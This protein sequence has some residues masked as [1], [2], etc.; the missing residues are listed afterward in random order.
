MDQ[1][2]RNGSLYQKKS[3]QMTE[4][5]P[6]RTARRAEI[7]GQESEHTGKRSYDDTTGRARVEGGPPLRVPRE[8]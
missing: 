3:A 5:H 8:R 6:S 4:Q 1:G 2:P 7:E